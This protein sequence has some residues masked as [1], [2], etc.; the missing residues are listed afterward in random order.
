LVR[1]LGMAGPADHPKVVAALNG[2]RAELS[3]LWLGSLGVDRELTIGLARVAA[4][5]GIAAAAPRLARMATSADPAVRA[6]AVAA[7]GGVA[8]PSVVPALAVAAADRDPQV[9]VAGIRALGELARRIGR[10]DLARDQLDR[11]RAG[12]KGS[13]AGV[14]PSVQAAILEVRASLR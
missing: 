10:P 3:D 12:A 14:D 2:K 8:G 9:A 4:A 7:L 11:L 13:A 6:A 1:L 5:M